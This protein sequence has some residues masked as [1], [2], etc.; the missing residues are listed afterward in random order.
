[1]L[2]QLPSSPACDEPPVVRRLLAYLIRPSRWGAVAAVAALA[3]GLAGGGHTAAAQTTSAQADMERSE[4]HS[5]QVPSTADHSKFKILQQRFRSGAEVSEACLTCHTEAGKQL[6]GTIHWTWEFHNKITGQTLG[7]RHVLNNYFISVQSNLNSCT[8]CHIGNGWGE[9]DNFSFASADGVDC[10]ICH[11]TTGEYPFEKFHNGQGDCTAC[12]DEAPDF[13]THRHPRPDLSKLAMAVGKPTRESCG[14]CHFR[15]DGGDGYKHGDLDSSLIAPDRSEDVHMAKDGLNFSCTACH[16]AGGH[17]VTGS[18]YATKSIDLSGI[19]IPGHTD[20]SRSTCESCHGLKPHPESNHPKLND[21]TDR[22]ACATCHIPEF[23]RGGR[24]TLVSW[25]WSTAGQAGP[26]GGLR[27]DT[28]PE[29]Y[30]TY[31]T[32]KGTLAWAANVVPTYRWYDGR[33]DY[34]LPGQKIDPTKVV[35]LNRISGSYDEKNARIWP[36]KVMH[37]KQPYDKKND[38]LAIPHLAGEDDTSYWANHDWTKAVATGMKAADLPFS[39]EVG[40]VQT[41]YYW[42]IQHMVAPKEQALQC[43]DCHRKGG[44]LEALKGFYMPGRDSYAWLT[45]LGWLGAAGALLGALGHAVLRV[46]SRFVQ[47]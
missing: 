22:V 26:G 7:M 21:H 16:A 42:P 36:F 43:N 27:V 40:F 25:D 41:R 24:K 17:Q 6:H 38:L 18:R 11:D 8:Q 10:L 5:N 45:F 4:V 23:A 1:M 30:T 34:S 32:D 13:R 39:G 47:K 12:H 31:N 14:S 20:V 35:D 44:R 2:R 37:G 19:D 29:G 3:V 9:D 15:G 46:V 33:I 28:D